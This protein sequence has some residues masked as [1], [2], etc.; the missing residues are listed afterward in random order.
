MTGQPHTC[1]SF[2]NN[3]MTFT[4]DDLKRVEMYLKSLGECSHTGD[5]NCMREDGLGLISR[6]K[7]AERF[8]S[9]AA[10]VL[11]KK[12]PDSVDST[13]LTNAYEAWCNTRKATGKENRE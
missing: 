6:L 1:T 12:H 2:T 11:K 13:M 3:L 9:I 8:G 5:L 7:A 4:D 10:V